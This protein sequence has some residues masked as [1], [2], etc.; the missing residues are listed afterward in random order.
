MSRLGCSEQLSTGRTKLR[1]SHVS[2]RRTNAMRYATKD[3]KHSAMTS[4]I[5]LTAWKQRPSLTQELCAREQGRLDGVKERQLVNR[6]GGALSGTAL[7]GTMAVATRKIHG[8]HARLALSGLADYRKHH[9]QQTL[10]S[11][12]GSVVA[13]GINSNVV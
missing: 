1:F 5:R 11:T 8:V 2:Q 12:N 4:G 7:F 9:Y 6:S 13:V 10:A 3:G